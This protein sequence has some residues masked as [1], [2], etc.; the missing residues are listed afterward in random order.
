[1]PLT[2]PRRK[3]GPHQAINILKDPETDPITKV[4]ICDFLRGKTRNLELQIS[5]IELS[6]RLNPIPNL[7]KQVSIT[8]LCRKI[9]T[10]SGFISSYEEGAKRERYEASIQVAVSL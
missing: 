3:L 2:P 9:K 5:Q 10:L 4:V 1:M 8:L 6:D 7:N